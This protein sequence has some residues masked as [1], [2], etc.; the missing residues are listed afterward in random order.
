MKWLSVFFKV[1]FYIVSLVAI[2]ASI[3]IAYLIWFQPAF[4]FPKPT[5]PYAIGTKSFHWID[6][7]RKEIYHDD[8]AHPNRELMVKIW[9][10]AQGKLSTKPTTLY[11]PYLINYFKKHYKLIWLLALS[12][13]SYSYAKHSLEIETNVSQLPVIIY[14]SGFRFT[15]DSNTAQCEE[16]ASYGYIVVGISHPYDNC[17][18][19]FQDGRI[20]DGLKSIAKRLSKKY[21]RPKDLLVDDT[22]EV[23]LEDTKFVLDQLEQLGKNKKSIF[24]KRFDQK[25]IGIFGHSLGGS[26]AIKSIQ[27]DSRVKAA[28]NVDGALFGSNVTKKIDKPFMVMLAGNSV[29]MHDRALTKD[30]WEKFGISSLEEE[31]QVKF[32][33]LPAL[34]QL[35]Q[36]SENDSYTFVF[37]GA[38]HLDFS[39]LALYKY[40]SFIIRSLVKLDGSGLVLGSINGFR[41]TNIVN[42][43]LVSFFD[44]YLKGKSSIL[45]NSNEKQYPEVRIVK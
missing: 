3:F 39:D 21:K 38:G 32:S 9:Y 20:A 26:T 12:R 23:W 24:Y 41:I 15:F 4:N 7:K 16:L 43:Y 1:F 2:L 33:Y 8:Q 11:A 13:Q 37:N 5:G 30:E 34:K 45:L 31:K 44:K 35:S 6:T 36:S 42:T 18:V 28:V 25:N 40:K 17:V 22:A 29:E 10:P 19:Q 27:N 14:S